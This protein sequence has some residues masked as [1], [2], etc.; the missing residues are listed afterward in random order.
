LALNFAQ[1]GVFAALE[2]HFLQAVPTRA[3]RFDV[4]IV[5]ESQDFESEWVGACVGLVKPGGLL[6]VMGDPQQQ[7][8]G[9]RKPVKGVGDKVA[10]S[11]AISL[12]IIG[13]RHMDLLARLGHDARPKKALPQGWIAPA[14]NQPGE[15]GHR[16]GAVHLLGSGL[17][18]DQL[19]AQKRN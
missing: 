7:V 2:Q 1:P 3:A 15:G 4:V 16:D 18:Q 8:L 17:E 13:L 5:D 11:A 6:Y 9:R 19:L 12:R 10:I 14:A